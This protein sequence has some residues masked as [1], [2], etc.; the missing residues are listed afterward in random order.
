M[1][2]GAFGFAPQAGLY[3]MTVKYLDPGLASLLL[4]LYPSFVIGLSFIFLS[5][6]PRSN[7]IVALILSSIGCV[8]T[9]WTRGSYPLIGYVFGLAVAISYAAYLLVGERVIAGLDPIFI[10]ANLMS[11]SAII[12]WVATLATG[13]FMLPATPLALAGVAGLAFFGSILP[14]VTLFAAI[15]LIGSSD[16]ALVSTIE[17]LCTVAL[18]ALFFGERLSTLQLSGGFLVM[19]GVLILNL[20]IRRKA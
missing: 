20:R 16:T 10:T 13:A 1:L 9:L 18:S 4:Y 6:K 8:L 5:R 2:L 17:P 12:Y 7:Q 3:F 15:R 14:I 11:V 19:T